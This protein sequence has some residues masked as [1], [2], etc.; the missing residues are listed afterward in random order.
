MS[1]NSY[2]SGDELRRMWPRVVETAGTTVGELEWHVDVAEPEVNGMLGRRYSIPFSGGT[3]PLVRT[4]TQ[5]LASVSYLRTIYVSE[6]P[7]RS[8]WITALDERAHKILDGLVDG[9]LALLTGSGTVVNPLPL[10]GGTIWSSTQGYQPTFTA[11]L[12]MFEQ[13]VDPDRA[14]DERDARD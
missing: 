10:A 3:P 1:A 12:P 2:S 6:D 7:A 8:D 11:A 5:L 14:D 13:E 9:T 4:V